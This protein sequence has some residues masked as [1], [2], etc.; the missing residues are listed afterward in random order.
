MR[1]A[2]TS[3]LHLPRT[4]AG[5]IEGMVADLAAHAPDAAVLAGDL[6]ESSEDFEPCLALFRKLACCVLVLAGNHDLFPGR[7]GSRQLWR[8]VLPETVRQLG[9]HWLEGEP[10]VQGGVAV[11]GTVAWSDYSAADLAVPAAPRDFAREKHSFSP[12]DRVDW[13]WSD[14]EF[15]ALVGQDFLGVLDRLEADAGVKEV[16]VVTHMPILDGQLLPR[17]DNPD[18]GFM[19]AYFGNLTPGREVLRRGKV[20]HVVS[21]HTHKGYEGRLR[22]PGGRGAEV[23]VVGRAG[24]KSGWVPLAL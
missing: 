10:F 5:V 21:G 22:L 8:H 15:A 12:D 18:L 9:F 24:G 17:P 1:L 13:P 2:V 6:G 11:A 14:Q 23:R 3:D 19:K 16:V 4:P 7:A 20:T